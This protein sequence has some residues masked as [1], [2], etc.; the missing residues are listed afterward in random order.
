M[1]ENVGDYTIVAQACRDITHVCHGT[2]PHRT[3]CAI[4][5]KMEPSKGRGYAINICKGSHSSEP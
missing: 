2:V 1:N 4:L 5:I 3:G